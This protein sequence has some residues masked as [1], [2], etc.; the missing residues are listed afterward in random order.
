MQNRAAVFPITKPK[1]EKVSDSYLIG[2]VVSSSYPGGIRRLLNFAL[3]FFSN[4][5]RITGF[6]G[7]RFKTE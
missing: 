4:V 3:W 1:T 5:Q 7:R 6:V 2:S